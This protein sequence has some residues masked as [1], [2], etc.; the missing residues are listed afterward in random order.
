MHSKVGIDSE[1]VEYARSLARNIAKD[2]QCFVD[3]YTTI[4]VERTIARL[5]GIDGINDYGVPYPNVIV[6]HLQSKGILA[7]GV[8]YWMGNAMLESGY[9]PHQI[10]EMIEVGK[11]DMSAIHTHTLEDI[12]K[13]LKPYID[14]S[15]ARIR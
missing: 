2:V 3:N 14:S 1:K 12:E 13:V 4:A 5:L 7:D 15:V 8:M 10:V 6:D 9:S 11:F